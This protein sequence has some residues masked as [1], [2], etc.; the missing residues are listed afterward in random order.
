MGAPGFVEISSRMVLSWSL[1]DL[2]RLPAAAPAIHRGGDGILCTPST[3]RE[4]IEIIA[5]LNA[6]INVGGFNAF[7]C[8][9]LR[10]SA[11]GDRGCQY[12]R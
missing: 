9:L 8:R 2:T 5:G 7:E 4:I 3:I 11:S 6:T 10:E 12:E 1:F